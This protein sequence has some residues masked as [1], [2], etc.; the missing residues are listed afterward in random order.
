MMANRGFCL[1]SARRRSVSSPRTWQGIR[2]NRRVMDFV[3]SARAFA[4]GADSLRSR[5]SGSPRCNL[6][7]ARA[8]AASSP[9]LF[10]VPRQAPMPATAFL[11]QSY[12]LAIRSRWLTAQNSLFLFTRDFVT[13]TDANIFKCAGLSVNY[14][15]YLDSTGVGFDYDQC[16]PTSRPCRRRGRPAARARLADQRRPTQEQWSRSAR[17]SRRG[18]RVS[19]ST[20]RRTVERGGR[21]LRNAPL[22]ERGRAVALAQSFA[23]KVSS[24]ASVS[25]CFR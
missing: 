8:P 17:R 14:Y 10:Q 15:K 16:S 22:C 19:S 24:T 6:Y 18:R 4:L 25:A 1:Q 21:R 13:R 5:R 12:A 3:T 20:R 7:L 23:K 2:T 9:S 11:G